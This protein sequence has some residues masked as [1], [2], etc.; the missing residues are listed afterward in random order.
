MAQIVVVDVGWR[1]VF[2]CCQKDS[3]VLGQGTLSACVGLCRY[4]G[5]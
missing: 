2:Y 5:I 1:T 4:K 3:M